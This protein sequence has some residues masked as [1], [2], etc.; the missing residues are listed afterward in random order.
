[1]TATGAPPDSGVLDR[2]AAALAHRGPDGSGH[3]VRDGVGLVHTRL[4][5]I[6]LTTGDQPLFGPEETVLVANG[7]IYNDPALRQDLAQSW[8]ACFHTGSDCE[9]PLHL[10][11]R[12]G[13]TYAESL[14]GMFAIALYDGPRKR[15]LLSRDPFGI[16]PLYV[17]EGPWGVAFASEPQALIAA[18]LLPPRLNETVRDELL[19]LQFNTGTRTLYQGITRLAPGETLVVE[20]GHVVERLYR[21][22]L[23]RA[24][25]SPLTDEAEALSELD[26]ALTESVTLHQRADVPY[27]MFLSGGID[28]SILLALMARLNDRPV[29]AYTAGFPGSA[30]QDERDQA[31]RLAASVGAEHV[32]VA[33]TEA[34]F[35]THLPAIAACMD[36]PAAD[37]AVVPT[38][39]LARAA[40]ADGLKVVLTGEGGDEL[41]AGYGRYRAALRPW[42]F[43]KRMR[44]RGIFDD[45]GVLRRPPP[46]KLWRSGLTAA[47]DTARQHHGRGLWALQAADIAD[48]LPNDLLIK[49]D[50]CLMAHGLEGRV[51]FL[52]PAVA[53]VALRL[54]DGLRV[55]GRVGKWALRRWLE[56]ALP[57][58]Q[59]FAD[60]KGFTVPVGEW[61]NGRGGELGPLVAAAPG[62][63]E[64]ARPEAVTALFKAP[65]KRERVAA[66]SLLFYALWYRRHML[67]QAVEGD[68]FHML[69]TPP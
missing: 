42:P 68:V 38:W 37:Y 33:I 67:G 63:V 43:A 20:H 1:M 64:L 17:A 5:I 6:D 56:G 57:A 18:G 19:Q 29:R 54:S 21:C 22:A 51:P 53:Q 47:E 23:P 30:V 50:R 39:L 8:G 16:K 49:L 4:A 35:W 10:Y 7:E 36:D 13:T 44:A 40:R 11:A 41:F 12:S 65:G 14:R 2:L 26:H 9:P 48:W 52:D 60:K 69:T 31:R 66:W 27:G 61:I 3:V 62:I 59:P 24:T 58:A 15:L 32:D 55:R 45:L 46:A 28:S 25:A 34:E